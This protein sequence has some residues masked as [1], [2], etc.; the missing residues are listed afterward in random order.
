MIVVMPGSSKCIRK[1]DGIQI[2]AEVWVLAF[3]MPMVGG[4]GLGT[5]AGFICII[6]S[7]DSNAAEVM[8]VLEAIWIYSS[9]F[10]EKVNY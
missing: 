4:S 6:T 7:K 3:S 10:Q 2:Q 1:E 8:V 9:Q 5:K